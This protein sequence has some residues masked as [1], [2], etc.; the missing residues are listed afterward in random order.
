MFE[1]GTT[2]LMHEKMD[3]L[4]KKDRPLFEMARKKMKEVINCDKDT[5]RHYKGLGNVLKGCQRAH[6]GHFVLV[7]KAGLERNFV[8][9]VD[10]DHH[11]K[12][13]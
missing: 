1:F 11:D 10:F 13:Y 2:D 4:S 9:F 8:L 12:I 6:I 3:K 7:F 5:I